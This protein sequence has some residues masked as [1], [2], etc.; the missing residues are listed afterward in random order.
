MY[1][2]ETEKQRDEYLAEIMGTE[3]LNSESL[4]A[5]VTINGNSLHATHH[6]VRPPVNHSLLLKVF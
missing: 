2:C 6:L 1:S 3:N 4:V 5:V